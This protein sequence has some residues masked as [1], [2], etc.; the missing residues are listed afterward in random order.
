MKKLGNQE[1]SNMHPEE[2]EEIIGLKEDISMHLKD[3]ELM[4]QRKKNT[5][6][7]VDLV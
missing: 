5:H 1:S 2:S 6:L 3:M 4:K 7:V